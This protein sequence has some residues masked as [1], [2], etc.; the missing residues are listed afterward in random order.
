[1]ADTS[2]AEL[3][4]EFESKLRALLDGT[5]ASRVTLRL[6]APARGF[7]VDDVAAEARRPGVKSLK[8]E[9]SINQRQAATVLWLDRERRPLVQEDLLT[10][11]PAPPQALIEGYGVRAQM[12]APVTGEG[13]LVGWVSVHHAGGPR[14]WSA[15]EVAL[16]E[17]TAAWVERR[18][19]LGA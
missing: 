19:G 5:G 14:S 4:Q 1:M 2:T 12:L 17:E 15:R 8:G 16:L 7:H 10:A 18:L 6:D 3:A 11:T 9:T 13:K